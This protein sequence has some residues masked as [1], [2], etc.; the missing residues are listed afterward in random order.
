MQNSIDFYRNFTRRMFALALLT[1]IVLSV[2]MPLAY[3]IMALQ[4]QRRYATQTSQYIAQNLQSVNQAGWA[5]SIQKQPSYKEQSIS[6]VNLYDRSHNLLYSKAFNPVVFLQTSVETPIVVNH[7]I[8]GYVQV[9]RSCGQKVYT[10]LLLFVGSSILGLLFATL[11]YRFPV[12]IVRQAEA[13]TDHAFKKLNHMSY[14]DHLTN[15]PNR[16]Q[17]NDRLNQ[18]LQQAK[19]NE[20]KVAVLFLDL[21]RFKNINDTLGHSNGDLLLQRVAK[22]LAN[23]MRECDTVA[24]LGGDEFIIVLPNI[25]DAMEAAKVAQRVLE[26]MGQPF[27]LDEHELVV[28]TSIGISMYPADGQNF[29][30]LV[31]NADNAM[32]RAKEQGRNKYQ[33]YTR[34]M[35]V[36]ALERLTLE[37]NLRKALKQDELVCYYQPIID[38]YSGEIIGMEALARWQHPERGMIFPDKFISLAEETGLIVPL[39]EWVLRTACLQTK[40]W[41]DAGLLPM[42]ISVNISARQFRHAGL[43]DMVR[44]VLQETELDPQLLQLEITESVAVYNED[45]VSAKLR[46]LRNLGIRIA[47]DDFGTGYSSLGSLKKFPFDSLKIDKSFIHN[48]TVDPYDAAIAETI[49][50]LA[51]NLHLNV[52]AEGVE[53][54]TQL[55]FLMEHGCS[56]MQGYL[57]CKPQPREEIEKT[58]LQHKIL[59]SPGFAEAAATKS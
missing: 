3:F 30:T 1:G 33:F 20:Q 57:F 22:R 59:F 18:A 15:L 41:Q 54:E 2:S 47:I 31:R 39:G 32:Y 9:N 53:D 24:R 6:S 51:N 44:T 56:A 34:A 52:I 26:A 50:A 45:R 21:D 17:L 13:E 16:L 27:T 42:Y 46:S 35:N 28:T 29:E 14:H 55:A 23:C 38:L 40:A 12:K 4:S 10:A 8:Y 5:S 11:L 7:Q 49:I 43:V 37:N 48:I 19:R 58:L 25:F 36:V